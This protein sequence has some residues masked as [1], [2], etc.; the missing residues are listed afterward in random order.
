VAPLRWSDVILDK[1]TIRHK[2]FSRRVSHSA[3]NLLLFTIMR[4]R[5]IHF[6]YVHTPL[7]LSDEERRQV[8]RL[9]NIH[10]GKRWSF[11]IKLAAVTVAL[12]VA[13]IGGGFIATAWVFRFV[14][15]YKYAASIGYLGAC[16]FSVFLYTRL[17]WN[18]YRRPTRLALR[19]LGYDICVN[20]GYWLRDLHVRSDVCPECGARRDA[21]TKPI[22]HSTE[23]IP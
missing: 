22:A 19:D 23:Q 7:P 3:G 13:V 1:A 6:G 15:N 4:R 16:A 2:P 5:W 10:A 17:V 11:R 8:E 21:H 12:P 18:W 9:S 14:P 20:C